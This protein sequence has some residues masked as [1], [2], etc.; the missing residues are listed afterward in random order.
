[1]KFTSLLFLA[2]FLFCFVCRRCRSDATPVA[3]TLPDHVALADMVLVYFAPD[4]IAAGRPANNASAICRILSSP[5]ATATEDLS[6]ICFS[7]REQY[8][9]RFANGSSIAC[10]MDT[11]SSSIGDELALVTPVRQNSCVLH[12]LLLD[13]DGDQDAQARAFA[14]DHAAV[15]RASAATMRTCRSVDNAAFFDLVSTYDVHA[16]QILVGEHRSF[17]RRWV[18]DTAVDLIKAYWKSH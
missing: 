18:V 7:D 14:D 8:G 10:T 6:I 13:F 17:V 1:M 12:A 2:L 15:C 9:V 11:L 3:V 16:A 5:H 4:R